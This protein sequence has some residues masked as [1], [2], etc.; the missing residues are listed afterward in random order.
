VRM[1]AT[2][3]FVSSRSTQMRSP[4]ASDTYACAE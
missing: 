3:S 4:M 2:K 1:F